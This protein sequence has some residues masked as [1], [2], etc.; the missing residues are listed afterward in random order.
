[1]DH[2]ILLESI[3]RRV[4]DPI[5]IKLIRDGLQARVFAK[6]KSTYI[7]EIGT[8]QGGILSPLLS[9]IYLDEFDKY[10]NTLMEEY[11]ATSRKPRRNPAIEKYYKT[12]NKSDIYRLRIPYNDPKDK[13]NI[14]L[15]YIRYAD[16][17]L[18]GV[19]G[20]RAFAMN[21]REKIGT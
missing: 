6:D 13:G 21:I 16:D 3:Q 1:M 12:K 15:K 9:N 11:K 14:K 18:L 8:P 4:K 7:P 5:I 2:Q 20:D 10:V 17:F 19:T